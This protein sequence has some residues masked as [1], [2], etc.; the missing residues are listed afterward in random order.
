MHVA[1]L[2]APCPARNRK[3]GGCLG[4]RS[5]C[6]HSQYTPRVHDDVICIAEGGGI[7]MTSSCALVHTPRPHVHSHMR[8]P[9]VHTHT[10]RIY[11]H[12]QHM[13]IH[14]RAH[15]TYTH[16][17]TYHIYITL[18]LQTHTHTH[19][20][21]YNALKF[22]IQEGDRNHQLSAATHLLCASCAGK[23]ALFPRLHP[24]T[25]LGSH[26]RTRLG[27]HPRTRLG[28]HPRT[29]LGSHPRTRLGSQTR[30]PD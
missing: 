25:R 9:H 24:R 20:H 8:T 11:I 29:G 27:S 2:L 23:R 17:H 1:L 30:L 14:T 10:H 21:S 4:M 3:L 13:H 5:T 28:S 7:K 12:T 15:H 19:T 22:H 18:I 16:T 26:P 6:M